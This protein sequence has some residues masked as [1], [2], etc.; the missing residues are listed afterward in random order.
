MGQPR[1]WR[2]CGWA[3][4]KRRRRRSS[5]RWQLAPDNADIVLLAGR[6]EAARRP[7]RRRDRAAAACGTARTARRFA[8]AAPW[9]RSSSAPAAPTTSSEAL[10]DARRDARAR[11][12]QLAA[13]I[14][15]RARIAARR[16]DYTRLDDRWRGCG[17]SRRDGRRSRSSSSRTCS[18]PP[19]PAS[20]QDAARASNLL[21]NVLA[22]VPTFIESLADVRTPTEL[23]AEPLETLRRAWSPP[24]ATPAP[25][26]TRAGL[27]APTRRLAVTPVALASRPGS[28]GARLGPRL[29]CVRHLR[30][31]LATSAGRAGCCCRAREGHVHRA[32]TPAGAS[33][34]DCR[35]RLGRRRRDGRR[36]RPRRRRARRA[37]R[38]SCATTATARGAPWRRSPASPAR[39]RSPGPT[40]IGDADPDAVFLD[41]G[42]TA[43]RLR[44]PA[45]R[46]LSRES[47]IA[48]ARRASPP[49]ADRRPR[50]RRL[51]S[52]SSPCGSNGAIERLSPPARRSRRGGDGRRR[53]GQLAGVDDRPRRSPDCRRSRQQRRRRS[54][55]GGRRGVAHLAGR[56]AR[57]ALQPL[58][59]HPEGEVLGG[60]RCQRRR[61]ARPG[62]QRA[63][64]RAGSFIGQRP[65][66][67]TT[68]RSIRPR[69]QQSAGDQRINSFGVGGEI[70]VRSGLLRAEA[71]AHR[72]AGARR[73]R[74]AHRRST[75]PASSGPTACRRP[76]SASAWTT[77]SSP[78]SG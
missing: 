40:S 67:A 71:A 48:D 25:P 22:R 24:P 31:R 66:P 64:R 62:G 28:F 27:P 10:R 36:P 26:D 30:D 2:T 38:S 39:G 57:H 70:E 72:T 75:S 68:G 37:I 41:A 34:V 43:A 11:P 14:V 69:A 50:R 46:R 58:A 51:R 3:S 21:R 1:R 61:P 9:P 5:G 35:R 16:A 6:M 4:S 18:A 65:R 20:S 52:T 77:A 12:G 42:G 49:I 23:I 44:Q 63:G 29:R 15:E 53:P 78:S 47:P 7:A 76:S 56:R 19:R 59:A 60:G 54:G 13:C 17:R 73:P 8:P 33:P 32:A 55:R 45:G 74:Y